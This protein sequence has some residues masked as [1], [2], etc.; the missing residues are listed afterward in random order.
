MLDPGD[1]DVCDVVDVEVELGGLPGDRLGD[2]GE[3][4][5]RAADDGA[6]ARAPG[7]AVVLAE[8]AE[9]VLAWKGMGGVS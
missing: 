1:V 6:G 2:L 9:V 8:A 3:L 7:R 4:G 5:V